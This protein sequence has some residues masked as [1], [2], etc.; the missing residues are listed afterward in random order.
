VW[1]QGC[2]GDGGPPYGWNVGG[3]VQD[4]SKIPEN[5]VAETGSATETR[6]KNVAVNY[7]IKT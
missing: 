3:T 6:P 1:R 7:I 2:A 4:S 5:T